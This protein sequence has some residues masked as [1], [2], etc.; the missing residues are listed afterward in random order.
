MMNLQELSQG[1][2]TVLKPSGPLIL[3]EAEAFR[4]RALVLAEQTL[5]RIVIDASAVTYV[6][7]CG[8]EILLE[9]TEQM[10]QGGRALKLCATNPTVTEALKLTMLMEMFDYFDDVNQAV[11]SFL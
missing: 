8:L 10:Q 2:V 6:D 11:R 5:G 3:G 4:D 7:S 9:L 1:A